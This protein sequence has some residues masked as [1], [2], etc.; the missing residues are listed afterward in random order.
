MRWRQSQ[1]G[2]L[3]FTNG[4]FDL[5]HVGH[6]ALLE[7]A[8]AQGAALV[9]GVNSD[10][11]VR[12]LGKPGN[13]PLVPAPERARVLA[14]LAS[15]DCVVV[16]DQDTPLELIKALKPDV[17]IKGADYEPSQI[18]GAKEVEGWGGRV[19]SVPLVPNQSTTNLIQRLRG[20]GPHDSA[21]GR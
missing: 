17:L 10:A 18:V 13:R 12:R 4:V 7:G 21:D 5:L 16:F 14:A 1:S 15:V 11:S 6:V 2:P 3:A 20:H 8:R 9:V 19:V